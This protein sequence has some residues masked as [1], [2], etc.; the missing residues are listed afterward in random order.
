[1]QP[2]R[3]RRPLRTSRTLRARRECEDRYA[4]HGVHAYEETAGEL[5]SNAKKARQKVDNWPSGLDSARRNS[6]PKIEK[7]CR[8]C[9]NNPTR[10]AVYYPI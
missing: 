2:L 8:F 4:A 9:L 10:P 6:I 7:A 1:L 5:Y 3:A